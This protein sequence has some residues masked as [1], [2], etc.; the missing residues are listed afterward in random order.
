MLLSSPRNTH[1]NKWRN[2]VCITQP[3]TLTALTNRDGEDLKSSVMMTGGQMSFKCRQSQSLMHTAPTICC[4]HAGLRPSDR[5]C[6]KLHLTHDSLSWCLHVN[7][8]MRDCCELRVSRV[9]MGV[10]RSSFWSPRVCS[11]RKYHM[12]G[13]EEETQGELA[14][15]VTLLQSAAQSSNWQQKETAL[16]FPAAQIRIVTEKLH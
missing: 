13:L 6:E 4:H 15:V 5:Q 8:C 1:I 9:K 3:V 12:S 10:T 7:S 11:S 16:L 14:W 2:R